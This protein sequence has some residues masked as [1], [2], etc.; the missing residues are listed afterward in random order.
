MSGQIVKIRRVVWPVFSEVRNSEYPADRARRF[1]RFP[2]AWV[3]DRATVV[4]RTNDDANVRQLGAQ[5]DRSR[6]KVAGVECNRRREAGRF[7]NARGRGVA[8][9]D[10]EHTVRLGDAVVAA[11]HPAAI[12]KPL[13][14]VRCD[15]L[16]RKQH[17]TS[18]AHRD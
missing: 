2:D 16:Q 8:F 1:G 11:A 13:C 10:A 6:L 4:V 12:Q 9:G 15:K 3:A 14:S 7:M 17:A 5:R 18:V